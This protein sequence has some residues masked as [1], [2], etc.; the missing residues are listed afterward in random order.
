MR[1]G[2][3]DTKTRFCSR[4]NRLPHSPVP[5]PW[6]GHRL[7]HHRDASRDISGATI[8]ASVR[9][10]AWT[11]L[12]KRSHEV[13]AG[14]SAGHQQGHSQGTGGYQ[15]G[16]PAETPPGQQRGPEEQDTPQAQAPAPRDIA[17]N[18]ACSSRT[19]RTRNATSRLRD[20]SR[21]G[22]QTSDHGVASG[23]N[24]LG[25]QSGWAPFVGN[26]PIRTPKIPALIHARDLPH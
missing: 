7:E 9:I 16:T 15:A 24:G 12:G 6:P 26:G 22:S 11:P 5:G 18:F 2:H 4:I 3:R 20:P 23:N 10:T 8:G 1:T 21:L 19:T 13:T 25:Q 14:T 17:R